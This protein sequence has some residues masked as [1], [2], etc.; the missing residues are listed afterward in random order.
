MYYEY[1]D[2]DKAYHM[3]NQFFFGSDDQ[4]VAPIS[5]KMNGSESISQSLWLPEGN[6][7]DFR[8]NDLIKGGGTV[9]ASYKLDEEPVFVKAGSIIPM[10][11]PKLRITGSVLDTLILAVYPD[12][13]QADF[14]MYE[15]EGN[16]EGYRNGTCSFTQFK[17]RKVTGGTGPD[18]R[19]G[20]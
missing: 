9:T 19:A 10:Q 12:N 11:T 16:T 15:D 5:D 20:W 1:P 18:H 13:G 14:T 3:E 6:W 8:N 17:C 2:M 4:I 7:Y